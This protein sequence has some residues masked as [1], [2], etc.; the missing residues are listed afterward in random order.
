M[1]KAKITYLGHSAFILTTEAGK[2]IAFDPFL[3]GNPSCPPSLVDPGHVD[4]VALTHG[5]SDHVSS[6][7][8]ISNKYKAPI[9][10]T[11]ELCSLLINDG[12]DAR[13]VD[14]MNKGGT[15][16]PPAVPGVQLTMVDAHHSSSY[17]AKDGKTYYAGEAAGF[18][19]TLESGRNIY[20]AGDTCLFGDMRLI[21]ECFKP[22]LALLPIGD[23]FT[24]G[25]N[26]AAKAVEWIK[27]KAVIPIHHSTFP[28]L[29]GTPQRFAELLKDSETEVVALKPGAEFSF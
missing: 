11:F 28:L 15:I 2:R 25:P 27:P 3:K 10:A 24:M 22:V 18:V 6:A 19:I 13:L 20:A 4:L 23:R 9:A 21:H 26:A 8:D 7:I 16:E 12:A 5:H 17:D 29:S 14:R 1:E